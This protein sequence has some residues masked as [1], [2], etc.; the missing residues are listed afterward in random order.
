MAV[1]NRETYPWLTDLVSIDQY[2]ILTS[3]AI[4]HA[5]FAQ[6][7]SVSERWKAPTV[8]TY[9]LPGRNDMSQVIARGKFGEGR[10]E[11]DGRWVL[12]T[13]LYEH[14]ISL[15]WETEVNMKS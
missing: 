14:T 4:G 15:N 1:T 10:G 13:F 5:H 7:G 11:T 8:A 3:S 12:G 9:V 6:K 2:T